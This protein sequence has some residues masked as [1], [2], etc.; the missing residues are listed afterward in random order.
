ME[1]VDQ[2][3]RCDIHTPPSVQQR[4]LGS[5]SVAQRAQLGALR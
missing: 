2:E 3:V 1:G 4:A 5:C